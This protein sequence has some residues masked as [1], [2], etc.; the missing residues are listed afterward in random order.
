MSSETQ[1][2]AIMSLETQAR[3][4]VF[5]LSPKEDM[6]TIFVHAPSENMHATCHELNYMRS[7]FSNIIA[8]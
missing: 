5:V 3:M 6:I 1:A 7:S 8:V 2:R 4:R